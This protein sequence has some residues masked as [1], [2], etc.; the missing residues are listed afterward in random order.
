VT[1]FFVSCSATVG[2]AAGSLDNDSL[3]THNIMATI[4]PFAVRCGVSAVSVV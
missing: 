2:L 4:V 1:F 3:A